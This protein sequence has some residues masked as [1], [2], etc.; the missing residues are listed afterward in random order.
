VRSITYGNNKNHQPFGIFFNEI[1]LGTILSTAFIRK[2]NEN[3]K[4]EGWL[5]VSCKS[6]TH[7]QRLFQLFVFY[8]DENAKRKFSVRQQ[9][10]KFSQICTDNDEFIWRPETKYELTF[11]FKHCVVDIPADA[12]VDKYLKKL[13][14]EGHT[15]SI[16]TADKIKS[17]SIRPTKAFWE[18]YK[19]FIVKTSKN[20]MLTRKLAS[21]LVT[22]DKKMSVLKETEFFERCN[23]NMQQRLHLLLEIERNLDKAFSGDQQKKLDWLSAVHENFYDKSPIELMVSDPAG[24]VIVHQNSTWITS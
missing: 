20:W 12:G 9:T 17:F 13:K 1:N 22:R 8:I 14:K 10:D 15:F 21:Y 23:L 7:K 5:V 19:F 16:M 2:I 18:G 4:L 24:V 11:S 6:K 3:Y